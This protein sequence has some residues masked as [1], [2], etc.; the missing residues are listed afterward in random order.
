MKSFLNNSFV[1]VIVFNLKFLF[2]TIF[3]VEVH[4]LY[5]PF[6]WQILW[7]CSFPNIVWLNNFKCFDMIN[8]TMFSLPFSTL[9]CFPCLP[10]LSTSILPV[11]VLFENAVFTVDIDN[12]FKN[13]S[14]QTRMSYVSFSLSTMYIHTNYFSTFSSLSCH[15]FFSGILPL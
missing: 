6:L 7:L 8:K 1:K 4:F 13:I 12:V 10:L 9:F 3:S 15:K 14:W 5:A 11:S 2:I